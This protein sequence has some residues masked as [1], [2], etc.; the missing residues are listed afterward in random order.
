LG[1]QAL[2][3]APVD[4]PALARASGIPHVATVGEP[5]GL[6]AG[7][8]AARRAP[9][10][11]VLVLPIVFDPAESIPPYSERPEEIRARFRL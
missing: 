5:A 11:A 4:W 10:P 3:G 7:L 6:A 8:A 1:G 2:P 9:G